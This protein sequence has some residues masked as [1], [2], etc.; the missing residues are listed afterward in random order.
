MDSA[1]DLDPS[2]ETQRLEGNTAC[3]SD[4][5]SA[6]CGNDRGAPDLFYRLDLRR[7]SAPQ[8]IALDGR[9]ASG[10]VAYLLGASDETAQWSPAD[11]D[12]NAGHFD[13]LVRPRLYYLVIDGAVQSAGRFDL[14]LTLQDAYPVPAS[15]FSRS[16]SFQTC[17]LGSE[18]AC[19][20][21]VS[22]MR[23]RFHV[24]ISM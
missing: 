9:S 13:F 4:D 7:K 22:I 20:M 3:A 18:P 8:R 11:C 21:V 2:L 17:L 16:G 12:V 10:L 15:C 5:S 6:P 14:E 23:P 1:L 24:L 19:R